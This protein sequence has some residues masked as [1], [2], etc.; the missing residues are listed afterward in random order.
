MKVVRHLRVTWRDGKRVG[1]SL[2]ERTLDIRD[3]RPKSGAAARAPRGKGAREIDYLVKRGLQGSTPHRPP[4]APRQACKLGRRRL[5]TGSRARAT[6]MRSQHQHWRRRDGVRSA[7]SPRG[8]RQE[9]SFSLLVAVSEQVS[10]SC[11]RRMV[12]NAVVSRTAAP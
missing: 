1:W 2:R 11:R 6:P 3:I 5:D 7:T 8:E 10:A 9:A 12:R 4:P